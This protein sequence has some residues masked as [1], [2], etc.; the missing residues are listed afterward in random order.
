MATAAAAATAAPPAAQILPALL[1]TMTLVVLFGNALPAAQR[2]HRLQPPVPDDAR[3]RYTVAMDDT[4]FRRLLTHHAR[5]WAGYR[6]VRKGVK[7]RLF[8]LRGNRVRGKSKWAHR[9]RE[10]LSELLLVSKWAPNFSQKSIFNFQT[11]F[12]N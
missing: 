7:K 10:P 6:K 1:A 2:K 12:F 3:I 11:S 8:R 4:L 5:S 9:I